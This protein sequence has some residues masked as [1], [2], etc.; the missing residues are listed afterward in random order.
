MTKHSRGHTLIPYAGYYETRIT[1]IVRRIIPQVRV[2]T[3]EI[4]ATYVQ[5][6][7]R[8]EQEDSGKY[9]EMTT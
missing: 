4:S 5:K 3:H 7:K 2:R 8:Q 9:D 6:A 1:V